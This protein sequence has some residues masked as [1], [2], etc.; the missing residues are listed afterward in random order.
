MLYKP[1]VERSLFSSFGLLVP[2]EIIKSGS[3]VSRNVT[4]ILKSAETRESFFKG[5]KS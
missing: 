2:K 5:P 4:A 3:L 1:A